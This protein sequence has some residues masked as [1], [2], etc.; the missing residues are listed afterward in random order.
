MNV[1]AFII[2]GKK[3]YYFFL[4]C[5][6]ECK[7]KD[8]QI[9]INPRFHFTDMCKQLWNCCNIYESAV[10]IT[11]PLKTITDP[12]KGIKMVKTVPK[13]VP[14]KI[15]F[16]LSSLV[17]SLA[18]LF[19]KKIFPTSQSV[20]MSTWPQ[21]PSFPQKLATALKKKTSTLHSAIHVYHRCLTINRVC[22]LTLISNRL[23]FTQ[24]TLS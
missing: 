4:Y 10:S 19:T 2:S 17:A 21:S 7:G 12:L 15:F 14:S 3:V 23:Y 18:Q 16:M 13:K 5:A 9:N 1:Q 24:Y 22:T 6:R 11:S 20:G 8:V